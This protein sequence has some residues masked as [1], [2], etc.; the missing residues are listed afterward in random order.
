MPYYGGGM[1]I[2]MK[3]NLPNKL[4]VIRIFVVPIFMAFMMLPETV[5]SFK[6][7][8]IIGAALFLLSSLTDMVDGKL[9]RK[10]NQITDFGKFLDPLADKFLV[11][12]AMIVILYRYENLRAVFVWAFA[13][14]IF[15]ELAV[16]SIRL[17]A[18][19]KASVVVAA[20]ML[21][22]IKTVSQMT[23]VMTVII[24]PLLYPASFELFG[25]K[26]AEIL[27]LTYITIAFMTFMTILSGAS[28]IKA[29]WKY[30]DPEK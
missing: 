6:I 21:G 1:D 15:R 26:M 7:V 25:H 30:L 23:C 10:N 17:V 9:A 28:Y 4:T 18:S 11:I 16:T 22:K 27:P 2:D 24:E 3:M 20:N 13:V 12:S 14:V 5:L 8:S 29:C 19:T